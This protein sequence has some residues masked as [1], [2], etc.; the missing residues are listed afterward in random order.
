MLL[1]DATGNGLKDKS[2]SPNPAAMVVSPLSNVSLGTANFLADVMIVL[3]AMFL[4]S[5]TLVSYYYWKR[6][7][8]MREITPA[9]PA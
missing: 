2:P 4:V 3:V 5:G 8:R 1:A 7:K 9:S 6:I